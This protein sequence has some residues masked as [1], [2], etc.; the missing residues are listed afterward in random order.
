MITKEF[1]FTTN[2]LKYKYCFNVNVV[3]QLNFINFFKY[4][5]VKNK[6]KKI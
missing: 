6:M 5:F 2:K 3:V 4:I 1:Y